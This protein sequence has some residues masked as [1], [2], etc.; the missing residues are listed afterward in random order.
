[1]LALRGTETCA[2]DDVILAGIKDTQATIKLKGLLECVVLLDHGHLLP[3]SSRERGAYG[4]DQLRRFMGYHRDELYVAH[5]HCDCA[6][7]EGVHLKQHIL[8]CFANM[9]MSKIWKPL[10]P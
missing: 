10:P 1:M 8:K 3:L 5:V 9:Q 4:V 2:A 6:W 7:A